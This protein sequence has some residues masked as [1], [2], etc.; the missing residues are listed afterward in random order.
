MFLNIFIAI[1]LDS[2][3]GQA[4]AFALPVNQNSIDSFVVL[5]SKKEYD[6]H[7]VGYITPTQLEQLLIDLAESEDAKSLLL[8]PAKI[9][10]ECIGVDED[11]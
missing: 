10:P 5:W 8:E 4:G 9:I 2:F 11:G 1:I 7:A 6:P 3:A